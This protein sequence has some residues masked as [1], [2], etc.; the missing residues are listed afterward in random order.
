MAAITVGNEAIDR[1]GNVNAPKML[2][3]LTVPASGT[4]VITQVEIMA[5]TTQMDNVYVGIFYLVSG[6][7]YHCRSA[8]ANLGSIAVS[9]KGTFVVNLP[10]QIG[11]FIG[12]SYSAGR[13][14]W[15]AGAGQL[16]QAD[17]FENR[18]VVGGEKSSYTLVGA[19]LSIKGTGVTPAVAGNTTS[20]L[21]KLGL[22]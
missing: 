6:T 12:L 2:I 16:M 9:T 5:S 20:K 15:E 11:D 13:L 1:A 8:T 21:I 19:T 3:D 17:F 22:L 4:G 18:C 7:T 14:E 10:V